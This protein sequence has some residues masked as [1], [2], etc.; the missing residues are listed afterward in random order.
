MNTQF[1]PQ[2][3]KLGEILVHD[4]KLNETQVN[5]GLA[6]QKTT[7]QKLGIT[8]IEMGLITEDDFVTAY[9]LQL[10]YK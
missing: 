6:Q 1:N 3:S 8:L 10:G 7:N 5:E 2:F 9:G 4:Q